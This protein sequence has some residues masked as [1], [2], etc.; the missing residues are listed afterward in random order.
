MSLGIALCLGAAVAAGVMDALD[1]SFADRLVRVATRTPPP[2]PSQ[3]P[4]VAI[5]AVDA[6]SL[7]ALPEWPW[8]RSTYAHAIR[9]L[10]AAGARAIAF[11]IDFS[12]PQSEVEDATF[13]AAIAE[14]GRVVLA[15][16]RQQQ[17]LAA[18]GSLEVASIPI[19]PLAESAA[20]LGSVLVPVDTDGIVRSAPSSSEI[21]GRAFPSLALAALQIARGE[22]PAPVALDFF[23]VDYRRAGT[24]IPI[25]SMVDL[26]EGRY[27]VRD[28]SGRAV[29]IGA[30]AAE[31]HDLWNTPLGPAQPGVLIQALALRTLAAERAGA[32]VLVYLSLAQQL[33]AL[34]LL[35]LALALTGQLSHTRRLAA[36]LGVSSALFAASIALVVFQGVILPG[37]SLVSVIACHY[38]MGL[39]TVRRRFGLQI[40]AQQSSL[41]ALVEVGRATAGSGIHPGRAP[42]D[43]I[44][45]TLAL[46]GKVIGAS[47]VALLGVDEAGKL[48]GERRQ[49]HSA[50]ADPLRDIGESETAKR[51]LDEGAHRITDGWIP[52]LRPLQPN[53]RP[54]TAIYWPLYSSD[55]AVGVLV[56]EHAGASEFDALQLQT[57]AS[58]AS[59]LALAIYNDRLAYDLRQTFISS[60]AALAS[61]VEARDGYTELHCQRLSTFSALIARRMNLPEAEIAAIELGALLHDVGKI[62]I[63]D[64]VLNKPGRFTDEERRDMMRHPEIG[65]GIVRTIHGLSATTLACVMGHHER[66][67]GSG[68][69]DGIAGEDIPL[70]ARIVA[71]VDVWD[72]LSSS[73]PYKQPLPQEKVLELLNKGR[74][75]QF[76][77]EILDLLLTILSEQ[78]E[79]ML[80]LIGQDSGV[81]AQ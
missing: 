72:A 67:D 55:V 76:D 15:L 79:E 49:W 65:V 57:I 5:V 10:E 30:T 44:D 19:Q 41:A 22:R 37:I 3:Q 70:A 8:P 40:A 25:V 52:G 59:Q 28:L 78:G 60:I 80:E 33:S 38:V 34:L 64:V 48:D 17:Q 54:G 81:V 45:L 16:F 73:R 51:V 24:R 68:Y 71:V 53:T 43:G 23:P 2:P 6:Q 7:R 39:E 63:R 4:D 42:G 75:S 18:G 13:A 47:G 36:L 12:S 21:V 69:P 62:G 1:Q 20:A 26:L 66:W 58:S 50:G 9:A 61:A 35:S 77:P 11:D 56:V 29:F 74:G 14:S 32:P 27:D 46:L 31:F